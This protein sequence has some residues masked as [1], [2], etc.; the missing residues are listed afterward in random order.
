MLDSKRMLGAAI[1]A[2]SL[3]GAGT[4]L[5]CEGRMRVYDEYH[6]DYHYWNGDEDRAYRHYWDQRHEQYR[7]YNSL[8][9]NEQ[10]DYWNWR[11]QHPD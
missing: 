11:H 8:N 6:H 10:R 9:K 7:D 3:V 2:A 4:G 1:L 5:G